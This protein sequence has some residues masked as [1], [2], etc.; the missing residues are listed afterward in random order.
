MP[1]Y[2]IKVVNQ[3]DAPKDYALF[4]DAPKTTDVMG[5]PYTNVY[6]TAPSVG[7]GSSAATFNITEEDFAV[8]GMAAQ[9]LAPGVS[10]STAQSVRIALG[11]DGYG[12]CHLDIQGTGIMFTGSVGV[13]SLKGGYQLACGTWTNSK[14]PNAFCGFGKIKPGTTDVIPVATWRARSAETYNVWPKVSFFVT[15][16]SYAE[17][18]I[19]NIA[20]LGRICKVDFTGMDKTVA[21]VTQLP[22]GTYAPV[23][24]SYDK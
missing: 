3:D 1:H 9:E 10:V 8:C 23:D 5:D 7:T 17:G 6:V 13:T 24:Y 18:D 16:G 2:T 22:N 20:D 4:C 14:F 11:P 12:A 21:T 19:V 15:T